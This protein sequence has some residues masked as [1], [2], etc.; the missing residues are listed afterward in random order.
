MEKIELY[1]KRL[2]LRNLSLEDAKAM[3]S[4]AKLEYVAKAAGWHF[5]CNIQQT[6]NII[7][8]MMQDNPN[9]CGILSIYLLN[10]KMIGTIELHNYKRGINAE[11]GYVINPKYSNRGYCSEASITIM[12]WGFLYKEL[13]Y[14]N[15]KAA[16]DNYPSLRVIEKIGFK[17]LHD[18]SHIAFDGSNIILKV[19]QISKDEFLEKYGE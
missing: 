10:G 12:R 3:F 2:C 9:S 16:I 17:F 18:I 7:S 6:K 8:L 19:F 15:V 13:P 5:H 1:T 4:Y 11:L 14:I